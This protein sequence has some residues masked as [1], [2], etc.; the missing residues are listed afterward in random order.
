MNKIFLLFLVCNLVWATALSNR[1][2]ARNDKEQTS[3]L[4]HQNLSSDQNHPAVLASPPSSGSVDSSAEDKTMPTSTNSSPSASASAPKTEGTKKPECLK[5]VDLKEEHLQDIEKFY[6]EDPRFAEG[7]CIP[8]SGIASWLGGKVDSKLH[9]AFAVV[10]PKTN[11]AI[12]FLEYRNTRDSKPDVGRALNKSYWGNRIMSDA[13]KV[14]LPLIFGLEH[15]THVRS[16]TNVDNK[17]SRKSLEE[18]GFHLD[19]EVPNGAFYSLSR[20]SFEKISSEK[21]KKP[22]SIKYDLET[23]VGSVLTSATASSAK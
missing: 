18:A 14:T 22:T 10:D 6:S 12:A 11:K 19:L 9:I 15:I 7:F 4:P 1:A 20:E 13:L 23:K 3:D 5:I 2:Y 8:P 17:A 21:D 16:D